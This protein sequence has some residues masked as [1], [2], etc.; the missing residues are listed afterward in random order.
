M[1]ATTAQAISSLANSPAFEQLL[2]SSAVQRQ[3][4]ELQSAVAAS[5]PKIDISSLVDDG[6][7]KALSTEA[8]SRVLADFQMSADI[9]K[10]I[11]DSM[12]RLDVSKLLPQ[13]T[14][15]SLGNETMAALRQAVSMADVFR[16]PP[17]IVALS[18]EFLAR[19]RVDLTGFDLAGSAGWGAGFLDEVA[20][21][22]ARLASSIPSS[23]IDEVLGPDGADLTRR[24]PTH[25]EGEAFT[26][27]RETQVVLLL[28]AIAALAATTNLGA[29]Q[30]IVNIAVSIRDSSA[31]AAELT[32]AGYRELSSALPDD[33]VLGWLAALFALMRWLRRRDSA[34]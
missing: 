28:L 22:A 7:F 1:G 10:H 13:P 11:A 15:P 32:I 30:T 3:I 25:T 6:A 23:M 4:A 20:A 14:F 9:Q 17:A 18:D 33:N 16:A 34:D 24:P 2:G 5:V 26:K 19:M 29:G 27:G 12:P 8:S 21:A 31:F